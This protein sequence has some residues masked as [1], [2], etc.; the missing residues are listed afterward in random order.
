MKY[1]KI[2]NN[3]LIEAQALYLVGASTKRNDS[4]KIGQFGHSK[5]QLLLR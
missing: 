2:K 4:T 5:R 3:G 1:I